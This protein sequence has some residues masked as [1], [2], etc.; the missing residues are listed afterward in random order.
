MRTVVRRWPAGSFLMLENVEQQ[1][2]WKEIHGAPKPDGMPQWLLLDG[3]QRMTALYQTLT[4]SAEES[5]FI[6]MDRL[7]DS[8][9]DDDYLRFERKSSFVRRYPSLA[10]T[11]AEKIA[12]LSVIADEERFSQWISHLLEELRSLMFAIKRDKLPG[13]IHYDIPIVR[14]TRRVPLAAVAKVFETLNRTGIKL[15]TFDL[16]IA[17][18]YPHNF[19]LRDKWEAAAAEYPV[20]LKYGVM[21]IDVLRVIALQEHI[22]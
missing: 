19:K 7:L 4:D 8:D 22:R 6:H 10:S 18:L 3:Q 13:L 1:L 15:G 16:M 2:P 9:F 12:T 11:A 14:L 21:G 20:L 5:Y 17:M